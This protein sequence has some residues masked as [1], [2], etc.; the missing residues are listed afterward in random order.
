MVLL[1]LI[2][3]SCNQEE[4]I[5][6]EKKAKIQLD[7]KNQVQSSS[8]YTSFFTSKFF[9]GLS[10][11]VYI[12]IHN[13]GNRDANIDVYELKRGSRQQKIGAFSVPKNLNQC[14]VFNVD[15][16]DGDGIEVM[17]IK[18]NPESGSITGN[19]DVF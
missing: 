18:T 14:K 4:K 7:L 16:S 15:L 1:G 9:Y 5:E 3:F 11:R 2:T 8:Y 10:G 13:N 12:S 6:P 17:M 19:I